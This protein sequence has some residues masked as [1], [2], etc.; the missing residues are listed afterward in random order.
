MKKVKEKDKEGREIIRLKPK[1]SS[2][3]SEKP[4]K[5]GNK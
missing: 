1:D 3:G 2:M 4:K 5:G